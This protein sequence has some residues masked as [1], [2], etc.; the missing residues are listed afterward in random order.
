[1][2]T[3]MVPQSMINRGKRAPILR[4]PIGSLRVPVE[5]HAF[6]TSDEQLASQ[7]FV[8]RQN[9]E[10]ILGHATTGTIVKNS[11]KRMVAT[12]RAKVHPEEDEEN[13][14]R[15]DFFAVAENRKKSAVSDVMRRIRDHTRQEKMIGAQ[16]T[17][18]NAPYRPNAVNTSKEAVSNGCKLAGR[19]MEA[20]GIIVDMKAEKKRLFWAA[21]THWEELSFLLQHKDA[22]PDEHNYEPEEMRKME[23][24]GNKLNDAM[25]KIVKCQKKINWECHQ[26]NRLAVFRSTTLSM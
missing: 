20:E 11:T 14:R 24:A 7:G 9:P 12:S 23:R 26:R 18:P 17:P 4:P 3:G 6:M 10:A 21:M 2:V 8:S 19:I 13:V 25:Q 15:R 22:H 5:S 16:P 1:M